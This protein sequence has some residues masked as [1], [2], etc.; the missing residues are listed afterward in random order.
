M[1]FQ[2]QQDGADGCNEAEG[3]DTESES[4][5]DEDDDGDGD[6]ENFYYA[7]EDADMAIRPVGYKICFIAAEFMHF[8][9][10][11]DCCIVADVIISLLS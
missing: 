11:L 10:I 6:V 7:D 4:D 3:G 9:H 1:I 5:D 8:C 2:P